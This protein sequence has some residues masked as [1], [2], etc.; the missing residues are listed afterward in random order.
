MVNFTSAFQGF[1]RVLEQS[2][3]GIILGVITTNERGLYY[4]TPSLTDRA[5]TQDDS[6]T[7][8][9]VAVRKS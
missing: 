3:P 7:I 8:A 2:Y 5:H 4:V 9:Q 1:F 6:D